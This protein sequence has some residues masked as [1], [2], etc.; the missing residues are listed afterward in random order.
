MVRKKSQRKS[1]KSNQTRLV[2]AFEFAP[3]VL[4]L[5]D[6][7]RK[8]F[9]LSIDFF[10]AFTSSFSLKPAKIKECCS[11]TAFKL[12]PGTLCVINPKF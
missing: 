8:L 12:D 2:Q 5:F 11:L 4:R 3:T 1:N 9:N 6:V 7:V 10:S